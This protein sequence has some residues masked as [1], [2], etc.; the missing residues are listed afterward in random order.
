MSDLRMIHGYECPS[1][2]SKLAQ[3]VL[4][5][6]NNYGTAI[7]VHDDGPSYCVRQ[8]LEKIAYDLGL[9]IYKCNYKL[10]LIDD[11][12]IVDGTEVDKKMCEKL[13]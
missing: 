2:T 13:D 10:V 3:R 7:F 4:R 9:E 8:E 12:N 11:W 1:D 6:L 5:D